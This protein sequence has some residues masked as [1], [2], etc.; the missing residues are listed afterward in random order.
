MVKEFEEVVAGLRELVHHAFKEG[1]EGGQWEDSISKEVQDEILASMLL[2]SMLAS[3]LNE[4]TK[5]AYAII[6]KILCQKT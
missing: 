1:A 5:K 3:M 6:M 4:D 2:V